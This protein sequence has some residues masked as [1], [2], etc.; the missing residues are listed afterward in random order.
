MR[1]KITVDSTADLTPEL[2]EKYNIGMVSLSVGLGDDI[3]LVKKEN[4]GLIDISDGYAINQDSIKKDDLIAIS[5]QNI[6]ES[7]GYGSSE[8]KQILSQSVELD[9]VKNVR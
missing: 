8:I 4:P 9:T 5:N 3:Y 7:Y 1:I 6:F 2:Y